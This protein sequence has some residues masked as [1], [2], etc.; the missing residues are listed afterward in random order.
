MS[1]RLG[2]SNFFSVSCPLG[3]EIL[4][5]QW[6]DKVIKIYIYIMKYEKENQK[7]WK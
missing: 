3:F 5:V 4:N 7:A 1:F 2:F 6:Y